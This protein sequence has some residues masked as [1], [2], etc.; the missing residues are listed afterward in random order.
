VQLRFLGW[1]GR[2]CKEGFF[3]VPLS[4]NC[5]NFSMMRVKCRPTLGDLARRRNT[6][7]DQKAQSAVSPKQKRSS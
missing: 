6:V 7:H 3:S 5:E 1:S 4:L 2:V